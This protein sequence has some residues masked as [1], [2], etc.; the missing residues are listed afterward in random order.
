MSIPYF[1][2][3]VLLPPL[4]PPDFPNQTLTAVPTAEGQELYGEEY[5]DLDYFVNLHLTGASI[6]NTDWLHDGMGVL[7]QHASV[8]VRLEL[9]LQAINRSVTIPFWDYTRDSVQAKYVVNPKSTSEWKQAQ[10]QPQSQP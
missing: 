10:A 6:R 4:P 5:H 8:T 3:L 2:S 7:T 1:S 9:A